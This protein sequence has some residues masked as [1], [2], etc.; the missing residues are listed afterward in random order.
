MISVS[1]TLRSSRGDDG[2]V[3][4]QLLEQSKVTQTPKV[5][6]NWM[7]KPGN[8]PKP[9]FSYPE[10][11]KEIIYSRK[12]CRLVWLR[13]P[14]M[15]F[16]YIFLPIPTPASN[17]VTTELLLAIYFFNHVIF[18]QK[19]RTIA[20]SK[21]RHMIV[22]WDSIQLLN[23]SSQSN[24]GFWKLFMLLMQYQSRQRKKGV[25]RELEH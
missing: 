18:L 21:E 9:F 23:A 17:Q 4:S 15:H 1:L 2:W 22:T 6:H 5:L 20:V 8:I 19:T 10:M 7:P 25:K 3:L 16:F 13:D 11:T 12:V 24:P 14:R